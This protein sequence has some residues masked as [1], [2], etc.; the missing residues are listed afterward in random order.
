MKYSITCI[1]EKI[2]DEEPFVGDCHAQMKISEYVGGFN[3]V[4]LPVVWLKHQATHLAPRCDLPA[5]VGES[6]PFRCRDTERRVAGGTG[7]G[8]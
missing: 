1:D 6:E 3:Q 7:G 2:S 5:T 4:R 8:L